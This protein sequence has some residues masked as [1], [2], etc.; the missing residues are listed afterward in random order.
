MRIGRFTT[1]Q[2]VL[3]GAATAVLAAGALIVVW[4]GEDDAETVAGPDTTLDHET[5]TTSTTV[6]TTTS[7]TAAGETTTARPTTAAPR[8]RVPG[9]VPDVSANPSAGS[10]EIAVRWGPATGATGYRVLRSAPAGGRFVVAAD[11]NVTTGATT[12]ADGVTTIWSANHNYRPGGPRLTTPDT[13]PWF[14]LI[15]VGN[16]QRPALVQARGLQ[17]RRPGPGVRR[18]LLRPVVPAAS[19]AGDAHRAGEADDGGDGARPPAGRV[20]RPGHPGGAP[21]RVTA[22]VFTAAPAL[23]LRSR[24][25]GWRSGPSRCAPWAPPTPPGGRAP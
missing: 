15:D 3:V 22:Q 13:S 2:R 6:P 18:L 20:A 11:I 7:T 16:G 21:A 4:A 25:P 1:K 19:V 14:E 10:G 8:G 5:T 12:E 23:T 24:S 17:R 9:P